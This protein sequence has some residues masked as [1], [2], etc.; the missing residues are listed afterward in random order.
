MRRLPGAVESISA[1]DAP[2]RAIGKA[3]RSALGPG[4]L[5]DALSGT[6]L[7]HALHPILTDVVIGSFVS[8]SLLDVLGGDDDGRAA[9]RLLVV[10]IA[11]YAPTAITGVSDWADSEVVDAGIRRVGLVHA[12]GNAVA[13]GL[14]TAS[15]AA[16]RNGHHGRG[17]LLALAGGGVMGAGA[18]LGGHLALAQGVGANQTAFDEGPADWASAGVGAGD[19]EHG[20]PVRVVVDDTPIMLV[21][22]GGGVGAL[23]DRCAHRGCSLSDGSIE[24]DEVECVCHGTRFSLRDGSLRRGPATTDQPAYELRER[25]GAIELRLPG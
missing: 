16:R 20:K 10:G 19:L 2:A 14:Y 22:H 17:K 4:A 21:R 11:A 12:A 25:G 1:L 6:W 23:H 5:K 9:E 24:G 18:Y 13:L 7:G 3:T 8:A 15:L